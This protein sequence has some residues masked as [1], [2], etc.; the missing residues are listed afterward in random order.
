METPPG[1]PLDGRPCPLLD[2]AAIRMAP[3][4]AWLNGFLPDCFGDW[5]YFSLFLL[6]CEPLSLA[7]GGNPTLDTCPPAVVVNATVIMFSRFTI[8]N[9]DG[10]FTIKA[11]SGSLI[12]CWHRTAGSFLRCSM[13]VALSTYFIDFLNASH[14]SIRLSSQ[15]K[16]VFRWSGVLRRSSSCL[17][18]WSDL[19]SWPWDVFGFCLRSFPDLVPP[20]SSMIPSSSITSKSISPIR[21]TIHVQAHHS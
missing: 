7:L 13:L 2:W 17:R 8:F 21:L 5:W 9:D 18:S 19:C 12:I 10:S 1:W 14:R 11:F 3:G 4:G 15:Y 16:F 20:L 6:K